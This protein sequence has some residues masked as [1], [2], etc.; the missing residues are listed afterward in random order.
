MKLCAWCPEP[1][2]ANVR[3]DTRFHGRKCRQAAWRL[4]RL[5]LVDAR[6]VDL[7]GGG[8]TSGA[9]ASDLSH[10]AGAGRPVVS[11]STDDSSAIVAGDASPG[12]GCRGL[13][14]RVAYADPPY[15]GCARKFYGT[16]E[17]DHPSLLDRLT[18]DYDAWALST[19]ARALPMLLP[20]CPP[21]IRICAWVKPHEVPPATYGLHNVWEVVL[22]LQG[23]RLRPGRADA[24]IALPA[25]L[26]GTLPGRKPLAFC[27]WL[28]DCLGM[29][30]GDTLD[31]LFPGT[32]I[33]GASWRE[34]S[35]G[36]AGRDARSPGDTFVRSVVGRS[37]NRRPSRDDIKEAI[38]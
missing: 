19:S 13:R 5:S 35:A 23:R 28:F 25:R 26:G 6:P 29:L 8:D 21:E 15:P 36:A 37:P 31:D 3:K 9:A 17:V 12:S 38:V 1:L 18:T 7:A 34:L 27:A 2:K 11:G 32:G 33:V 30:P 4:R 22:V 24:L 16:E 14:L 20:L 10:G